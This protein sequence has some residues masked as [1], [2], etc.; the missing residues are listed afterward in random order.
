MP[1]ILSRRSLLR[2][3]IKLPLALLVAN[4]GAGALLTAEASDLCADSG[5]MDAGQKSIRDSLHY[6]EASLDQTKTCSGCGFFQ[7]TANGC[8]TCIIFSGP[9]NSKGHCDSWSPKG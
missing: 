6:T 8:G 7:L 1:D 4:L 3:T 5:K 9:A 2:R